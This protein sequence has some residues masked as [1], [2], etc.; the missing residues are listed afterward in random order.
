MLVLVGALLAALLLAAAEFTTLYQ[1]HLATKSTPIESVTTG[2]HNSYAM[3][4]IAVLAAAF[5]IAVRR[6]GSRLVML[7]IGLLGL[8]ALLIALLHD[9]PDAHAVGL[10]RHN[11][12]VATTTPSVGIYL[13]TLGAIFLIA[14]SG[15]GLALVGWARGPKRTERPRARAT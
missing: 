7:G 6:T 10:A 11:S 14:V 12:V 1:A 2:S 5:G 15:I 8:V 3:I 4:P 9:L 13:E